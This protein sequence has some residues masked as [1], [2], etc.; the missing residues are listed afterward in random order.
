MWWLPGFL[1]RGMEQWNSVKNPPETKVSHKEKQQEGPRSLSSTS[2]PPWTYEA[3]TWMCRSTCRV[4]VLV[5]M[6]FYPNYHPRQGY[7]FTYLLKYWWNT[8]HFK[9]T[10]SPIT[11]ANTSSVNLAFIF[12]CSSSPINPEYAS[13]VDFSSLVFSLSSHRHS[14]IGLVFGS[15]FLDS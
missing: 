2:P 3:D 1:V 10:Y 14:Y 9:N 15:R 13:R 6:Q 5:S 11:L 12:R 8:Y 7:S 4:S